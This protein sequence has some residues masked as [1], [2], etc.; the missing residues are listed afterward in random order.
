MGKDRNG[1]L[2]LHAFAS[3]ETSHVDMLRL[4]LESFQSATRIRDSKGSF[5]LHLALSKKNF[6]TATILL[7]EHVGGLDASAT[8]YFAPLLHEAMSSHAPDD[9]IHLLVKQCPKSL[10]MKNLD[11]DL[12]LHSTLWNLTATLGRLEFFLNE[13]P[14]AIQA[15]NNYHK[16][17][18]HV[19]AGG[20]CS[21]ESLKLLIDRYPD[22]LSIP[23]RKGQLPI[24]YAVK[25]SHYCTNESLDLLYE[26]Y[27]QGLTTRDGSGKTPLSAACRC[28][29]FAITIKWI[30]EK[31][32]ASVLTK[33]A[34][35]NLP[36]HNAETF[37]CTMRHPARTIYRL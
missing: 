13:F 34:N 15:T 16:L 26:R 18:I 11:G 2:P 29:G 5:P 25:N 31:C 28:D 37:L 33:D 22:G 30:V 3:R 23:D 27:P 6:E 4:L 12:P 17:P 9:F 24:F 1:R 8:T 21:R 7:Q 10:K 14:D 35:G 32:P 36:V 19:E 20:R